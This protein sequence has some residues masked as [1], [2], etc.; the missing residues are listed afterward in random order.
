MLHPAEG[1]RRLPDYQHYLAA[2]ELAWHRYQ[3][4]PTP[5]NQEVLM[6]GELI[7]YRELEKPG[8][9]DLGQL[10]MT[11]GAG[12]AMQTAGH[13]PPEFLL[14][15]K[16]GDWGEVDED[17]RQENEL[18]VREGMRVLSAYSTRLSDKLWVI[19]E[20]DRSA[21]TLLLPSEY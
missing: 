17:D 16:Q 18:S 15:H 4:E 7:L 21:T 10:A 8:R 5:H 12:E 9:F 13:I 19:T 20:W 14:R 11:P 2:F 3:Q 1:E 6:A